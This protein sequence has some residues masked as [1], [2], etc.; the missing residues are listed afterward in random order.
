MRVQNLNEAIKSQ[1]LGIRTQARTTLN[2]RRTYKVKLK[3]RDN[4][5]LRCEEITTL[6]KSLT[7]VDCR[8]HVLD[9]RC[10]INDLAYVAVVRHPEFKSTVL[11]DAADE[12][13]R[14]WRVG[15]RYIVWAPDLE[16]A[17]D[18][19]RQSYSPECGFIVSSLETYTD[20]QSGNNRIQVR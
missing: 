11:P 12:L 20:A 13:D 17:R 19:I 2:L 15:F 4:G 10:T 9:D 1:A 6:T 14:Q 16:R 5:H 18:K 8:I 7:D 3:A